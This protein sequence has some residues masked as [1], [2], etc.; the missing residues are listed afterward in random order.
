MKKILKRISLMGISLMCFMHSFCFADEIDPMPSKLIAPKLANTTA[1]NETVQKVEQA[2]AFNFT[3]IL[4]GIIAAIIVAVII[5][6]LV[7]GKKKDK[8]EEQ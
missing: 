8:D 6:I 1:I 7:S 2:K 4:I 3:P 5:L